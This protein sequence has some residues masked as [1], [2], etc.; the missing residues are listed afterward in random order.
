MNGREGESGCGFSLD[1]NKS[2]LISWENKYYNWDLI[3]SCISRP[4]AE[5]LSLFFLPSVQ[6]RVGRGSH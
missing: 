2:W 1:V 5:D 6:G 4:E 3:V